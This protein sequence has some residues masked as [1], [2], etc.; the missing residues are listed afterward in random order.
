MAIV[1]IC[2]LY[3]HARD[4]IGRPSRSHRQVSCSLR[5]RDAVH[6]LPASCDCSDRFTSSDRDTDWIVVHLLFFYH[7]PRLE[8]RTTM[9]GWRETLADRHYLSLATR[10]WRRCWCSLCLATS[11]VFPR[12][13]LPRRRKADGRATKRKEDLEKINVNRL[14]GQPRLQSRQASRHDTHTLLW[15]LQD[16]NLASD[17]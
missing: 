17:P 14:V 9:A 5:V 4:F 12:L 8:L 7:A 6:P 10:P 11:S 2:S 16:G 13:F 15:R 3:Q 1:T